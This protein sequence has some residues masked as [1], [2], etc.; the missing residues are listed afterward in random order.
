MA[1]YVEGDDREALKAKYLVPNLEKAMPVF[2][3]LLNE[4][5]SGFFIKSGVTWVIFH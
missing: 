3:R 5:G 4:S 1:G 2:E